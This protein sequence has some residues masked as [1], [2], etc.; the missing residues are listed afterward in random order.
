MS[1]VGAEPQFRTGALW[2]VLAVLLVIGTVAAA[3]VVYGASNW[4]LGGPWWI[5]LPT[6]GVGAVVSVVALLLMLGVLYRVDRFRG[7]PHKEVRFFE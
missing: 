7:T 4:L 2:G 1:E 6:I 3:V 5:A